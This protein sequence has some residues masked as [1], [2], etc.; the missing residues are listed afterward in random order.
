[1]D[2]IP[3]IPV[4]LL[5][6]SVTYHEYSESDRWGESWKDPVILERVRVE[7]LQKVIRGAAGDQVTSVATLFVDS[8]NS[9]P[10]PLPAFTLKS[11]IIFNGNEMFVAA[12]DPLYALDP[13]IPHHWEIALE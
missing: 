3:Q 6:H 4:E 8:V 12:P 13:A 11:K 5:I 2:N 10:Q 1:M 7:P 9:L